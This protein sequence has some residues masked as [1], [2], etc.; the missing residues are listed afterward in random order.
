MG[1][2]IE[3]DEDEFGN[4][5]EGSYSRITHLGFDRETEHASV[6]VA[7][8]RD[9]LAAAR[10]RVPRG[11]P[12]RTKTFSFGPTEIRARIGYVP[13]PGTDEP[14]PE[15]PAPAMIE[16]ELAPKVPAFKEIFST[17]AGLFERLYAFVKTSAPF[18]GATDI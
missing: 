15:A 12:F 10:D 16:T 2:L 1:L 17:D 5:Y 8:Y 11:R 3:N 9:Q 7:T 14:D 4:K 18:V 6:V 13:A